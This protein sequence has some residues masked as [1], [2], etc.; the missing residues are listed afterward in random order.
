[1]RTLFPRLAL[2][3]ALGSVL[4]SIQPVLAQGTAFTYQGR[5]NANGAPA[6]GSYDL[7]FA[8][9]ADSGGVLQVG[10]AIADSAVGVTNGLFTVTLDFG[11][12]FPGAARWLQIGVRTNGVGSFTLLSPLQPLTPAPYSIT[13]E[14]A[15]NLLAPLPASQLAGTISNA[16]LPSSPAV[17]G[18]VTAG[19][20]SGNG[21]NV[22]NVNA[23]AL[24]GLNASNFWQLGG[25]SVASGQFIGSTNHQALE[26]WANGSRAL[27]LEPDPF[28]TNAPNVIGG[29]SWNAVA[30]GFSGATIA[31]GF[32]NYVGGSY[33][34]VGGG[35]G[36]L[37]FGLY[38]TVPGGFANVAWGNYTFAAGLQAQALNPGAFVWADSQN[39][40]FAST[41]SDQFLVRAQG[42]V[43]IGVNNPGHPLDVG[44]RLRLRQETGGAT[45]GLWL[46]QT[47]AGESAFIGMDNDGYV[48]LWGNKGVGWGMIMNV[49]N[50]NV[51]IG[52][53]TPAAALDVA[54]DV[55]AS[56]NVRMGATNYA[57]RA[58]ENLRIVRGNVLQYGG[59]RS[60]TGFT[61]SFGVDGDYVVTFTTPFADIPAVTVSA[62][63]G[64]GYPAAAAVGLVG[65][66]TSSVSITSN[67]FNVY[68]YATAEVINSFGNGTIVWGG[69]YPDF[70]F[71]AIGATK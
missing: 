10:G 23:V 8:L 30:S 35:G 43:G 20:F 48:G 14:S 44:G 17:S 12:N 57:P 61:T 26:L 36:N 56:G 50:G 4:I 19:S 65:V 68:F 41:A 39:T 60:G 28:D 16:N 18:T 21:A 7:N 34:T 2:V 15:N 59:I 46:Y 1:M 6:T 40:P 52:T 37:T 54:G 47:D 55:K 33:D 58:A 64:R 62:S 51:G 3:V 53:S 70:S 66:Q 13:A 5:L 27:R 24:N 69:S 31:G 25:N 22:T 63:G 71:I 11:A 38:A 42:G 67:S 32:N 49:T 29:S 9:Y 45:A